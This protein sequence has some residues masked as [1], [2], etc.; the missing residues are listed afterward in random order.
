MYFKENVNN[1]ITMSKCFAF[2]FISAAT[3]AVYLE[4]TPD[5]GTHSLIVTLRRFISRNGKQK[6]FI[7]DNFKSFRFKDMINYLRA[8]D[9]SRDFILD[10]S[11]W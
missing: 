5:V 3:L 8:V 10:K 9:V 6:L 11:L 7:T 4:L 2:L 1:C